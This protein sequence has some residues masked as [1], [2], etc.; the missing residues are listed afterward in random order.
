MRAL[1]L[2]PALLAFT[3]I[4]AQGCSDAGVC[5]A[6]PMGQL[7][8]WTDKGPD[9]TSYLHMARA[10]Y[11]YGIGDQGTTIMQANVEFNIGITSRLSLQAKLPYVWADGELGVNK[12]LGDAIG[13]LSY[14]F[15]NERHRDLRAIVGVRYPLGST[16]AHVV[17]EHTNEMQPLMHVE[18]PLPMVY[19]T[20]LGTTDLLL[21]VNA[22]RGRWIAGLAY[23]HVL[24]DENN[25]RFTHG[26]WFGNKRVEDYSESLFLE[27]ADDAVAR[28]QYAYGCGRLSL[29]PGLLGIYHMAEDTRQNAFIADGEQFPQRVTI[30]GSQGLTLNVTLDLLFKLSDHFAIETSMGTPVVTREERPDG[31]TREFVG[32][33]WMKYRF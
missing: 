16:D 30:D 9:T 31:L 28:V 23:Q 22:R 14:A 24:K 4:R 10:G 15:I 27:R 8:L 5:T 12:G 11:S 17:P 26:S 25:N 3:L 21:G 7:Q 6:G 18:R 32:S 33:V 1:L 13:T 20:G 29:Q 2:F 19:Q